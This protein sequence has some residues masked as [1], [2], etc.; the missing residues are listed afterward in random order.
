MCYVLKPSR[1]QCM[2]MTCCYKSSS[3]VLD[4]TLQLYNSFEPYL[5]RCI[6]VLVAL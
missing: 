6:D 3:T 5:I 4:D 1:K 2:C